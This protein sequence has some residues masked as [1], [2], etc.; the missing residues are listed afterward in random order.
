MTYE[1]CIR[2]KME[3]ALLTRPWSG[4]LPAEKVLAQLLLYRDGLSA[5]EKALYDEQILNGWHPSQAA[6]TLRQ[7]REAGLTPAEKSLVLSNAS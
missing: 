6:E 5:E 1:E 2:A 4:A 7:M 3:E